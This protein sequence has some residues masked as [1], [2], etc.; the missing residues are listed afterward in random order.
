VILAIVRASH[1]LFEVEKFSRSRFRSRIKQS[2]KHNRLHDVQNGTEDRGKF[3][4]GGWG[5][6]E[7]NIEIAYYAVT[8]FLKV[9]CY[10]SRP[11]QLHV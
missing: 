5:N 8:K 1:F 3:R 7:G 9:D 4:Y 11:V 10:K 6:I 2:G